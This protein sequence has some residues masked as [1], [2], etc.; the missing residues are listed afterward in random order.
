MCVVSAEQVAPALIVTRTV[1]VCGL[2]VVALE[3][4]RVSL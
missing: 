2:G 4:G 3:D 1:P